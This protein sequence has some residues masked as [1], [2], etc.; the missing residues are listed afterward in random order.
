[1]Q[2]I[3]LKHA[4]LFG[5]FS[6]IVSSCGYPHP[7]PNFEDNANKPSPLPSTHPKPPAGVND[8]AIA[9]ASDHGTDTGASDAGLTFDNLDVVDSTLRGKL[10]VL[11]VGSQ[12]TANN[13][14]SVFVGLKNK[15]AHQLD[16]EVQ[17]I[18]KDKDGQPLNEG[19]WIPVSLKMHEETEYHSAS[20]SEGAVD[21]VV[22][23][24]HAKPTP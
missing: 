20:I 12:P 4:A 11:R 1:M 16:L 10:A 23:V 5:I 21:F 2:T 8:T 22:S 9:P 18:Y 24:R 6:L 3:P 15:T 14:L 17:T 19:S 13:L 7:G